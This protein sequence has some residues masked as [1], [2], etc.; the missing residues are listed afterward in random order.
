M[1]NQYFPKVVQAIATD[2]YKVYTYFD[3]GSIK[4]LDMTEKINSGIFQ[5]IRD[6]NIFKNALTILNDTVA[7]D[8]NGKYDSSECIDIDPFTIYD[9]PDVSEREFINNIA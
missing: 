5:Q 2:E 4:C 3:D 7:W 6:I 8:L 1:D 9:L